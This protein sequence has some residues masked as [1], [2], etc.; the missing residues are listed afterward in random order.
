MTVSPES[1]GSPSARDAAE[2]TAAEPA[3]GDL[4][5][6]E[7]LV[8][9]CGGIAVYKVCSVVSQLVQRGAG[10]TCVMTKAATRFVKPLT[11]E[12]LSG[13]KVLTSLWKPQFSY[14]PQ[15]IKLTNSAD[16]FLVAP[17]TANMIGKMACGL[18]DDTLSTLLISVDCPVLVA[19]A[20]NDRM[21][22][23]KVVADN[24]ARL[25]ELGYHFIGPAEGWLACRSVGRGRLEEPEAIIKKVAD[26]LAERC[27]SATE[28]GKA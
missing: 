19:P 3:A 16:V 26:M 1:S 14:D 17:A 21:W 7:V 9:V 27:K 13:R 12:A 10:V 15:H 25:R 28:R 24:V 8:G 11:F 6:F 22:E 20:M 4:S 23:N 18:A 2:L 5:G